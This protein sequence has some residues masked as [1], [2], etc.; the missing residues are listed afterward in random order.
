MINRVKQLFSALTANISTVDKEFVVRHLTVEEQ[1]LFW[2]MNLPDQ[3]HALNVTYSAQAMAKEL[4]G[5]DQTV[6]LK[7]ALLHDVGKVRGDISTIDKVITVLAYSCCK[8]Q[9]ER[10]GRF[11]RGNRLQNL[12]HAFF[13]YFRHGER[14]AEFLT[15]I[16]ADQRIVEIIRQHHKAPADNDPPELTILRK[17][18]NLH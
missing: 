12:R 17:A 5:I 9:A 6:L 7:C 14:G 11:G 4:L 13:I 15:K 16:H 10:W 18:D 1:R 3:R 2:Q 8:S